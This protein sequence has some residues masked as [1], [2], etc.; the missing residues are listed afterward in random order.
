MN[1]K[2][3]LGFV[4]AALVM[5]FGTGLSVKA[6]TEKATTI[7]VMDK[8]ELYAYA[9]KDGFSSSAKVSNTGANSGLYEIS[10][11]IAKNYS[12]SAKNVFEIS[13]GYSL[14]YVKEDSFWCFGDDILISQ[15]RA[16]GMNRASYAQVK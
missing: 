10:G 11:S 16:H 4:L 14:N 13:V 7:E 15:I 8:A 6:A 2:K 1:M 3:R 5:I 9:K 12:P